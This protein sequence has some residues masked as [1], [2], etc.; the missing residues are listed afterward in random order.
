MYG[1]YVIE[2]YLQGLR[3]TY[4]FS[5]EIKVGTESAI[6]QFEQQLNILRSIEKRFEST[7]FDIAQL[8]QADLFDSELESSKRVK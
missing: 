2:D 8:V 7:L 6:P 5:G 1:N 3:V 4:S